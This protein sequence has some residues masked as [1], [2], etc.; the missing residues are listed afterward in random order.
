M[1]T[2]TDN[3]GLAFR[4]FTVQT[5]IATVPPLDA[6]PCGATISARHEV[7]RRACRP[8]ERIG[9]TVQ[10]RCGPAAV[11]GDDRRTATARFAGRR[12]Q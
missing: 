7:F 6:A 3:F 2:L 12:G 10:F 1:G 9:K 5:A 4:K 8:L 11:T